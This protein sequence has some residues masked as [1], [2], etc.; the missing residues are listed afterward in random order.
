MWVE[1]PGGGGMRVVRH[2]NSEED[3]EAEDGAALWNN[4][5]LI[6]APEAPLQS[7]AL[8]FH[9]TAEFEE[10]KSE[11]PRGPAPRREPAALG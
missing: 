8:L 1:S 6:P 7:T 5:S 9:A 11:G 10:E 3:E 4:E 2:Q